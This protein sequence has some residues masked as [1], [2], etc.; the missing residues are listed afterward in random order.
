MYER[1]KKKQE[2]KKNQIIILKSF[3]K[4][5]FKK[6]FNDLFFEK[7]RKSSFLS[8]Q[9]TQFS[10]V[11][12][13]TVLSLFVQH[14]FFRKR[15]YKFVLGAYKK[16]IGLNYQ[17][18]LRKLNIKNNWYNIFKKIRFYYDHK[19]FLGTDY[20]KFNAGSLDISSIISLILCYK[21]S[22]IMTSESGYR[23]L[24]FALILS[25]LTL[26]LSKRSNR[27]SLIRAF[28][29]C[30]RFKDDSYLDSILVHILG[31]SSS[32]NLPTKVVTR[33]TR[34]TQQIKIFKKELRRTSCTIRQRSRS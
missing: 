6:R 4:L 12:N 24:S 3:P 25:N 8:L 16:R 21:I 20:T 22:K 17:I 2:V 28:S 32:L 29:R 23:Q 18:A 11:S 7:L 14:G 5:A 10:E 30:L 26:Y 34:M 15:Y 33:T 19:F 13:S 1:S 31:M 27:F 9:D